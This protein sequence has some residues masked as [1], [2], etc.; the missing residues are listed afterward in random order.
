MKMMMMKYMDETIGVIDYEG[1]IHRSS[2]LQWR[3][4]KFQVFFFS[5]N[6]C[7]V[8]PSG[9]FQ[10]GPWPYKMCGLRKNKSPSWALIIPASAA[11]MP[12]RPS[13]REGLALPS[14]PSGLGRTRA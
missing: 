8:M 14:W 11:V 10:T 1:V 7:Q 6:P 3:K 5:Q 2:S 12:A 9:F 13:A 4:Q